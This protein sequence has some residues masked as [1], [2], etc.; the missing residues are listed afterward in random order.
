MTATSASLAGVVNPGGGTVTWQVVYGPTSGH[1]E[2][3]AGATFGPSAADQPV[4]VQLTGPSPGT[5]YHYAVL[6]TGSGGSA[7][8]ADLTFTTASAGAAKPV[9]S[10]FKI[11]PSTFAVGK[12]ARISYSLSRGAT[13]TFRVRR[14]LPGVRAGKRCVARTRKH[15]RGRRCTRLVLVKDSIKR[16]S[17]AGANTFKWGGRIGGHALSPGRYRLTATPAGGRTLSVSFKIVKRPS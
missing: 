7:A 11:V 6:A 4:S 17:T 3:T 1:G 5:T 8:G 13:V 2:S 16:P 15:P 14:L 12:G 9:L 10:K